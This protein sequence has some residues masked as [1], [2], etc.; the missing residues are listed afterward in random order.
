[1]SAAVWVDVGVCRVGGRVS[2][3]VYVSIQSTAKAAPGL[4]KSAY[5]RPPAAARR[6]RSAAPRWPFC[7]CPARPTPTTGRPPPPRRAMAPAPLPPWMQ[8]PH[9]QRWMLCVRVVGPPPSSSSSGR[10]S[11]VC[12]CP[13][14]G[15]E[16]DQ[17]EADLMCWGIDRLAWWGWGQP[18]HTHHGGGALGRWAA[19]CSSSSLS[20]S[21]PRPTAWCALSLL[22]PGPPCCAGLVCLWHLFLLHTRMLRLAS[23]FSDPRFMPFSPLQQPPHPLVGYAHTAAKA[24][25]V[26][27]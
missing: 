9:Q 2:Q 22:L 7:A 12:A 5:M 14:K 15:C 20:A 18:E 13:C 6:G 8:L 4:E 25:T 19:G 11:P 10:P 23:S 26:H 24:T 27:R 16:F 3:S 17:D 21:A 1:M